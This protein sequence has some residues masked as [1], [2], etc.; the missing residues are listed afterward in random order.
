MNK[1]SHRGVTICCHPLPSHAVI[2]IFISK[3][4]QSNTLK[5]FYPQS[6]RSVGRHTQV[7]H[8]CYVVHNILLIVIP[9]NIKNLTISFTT[10]GGLYAYS[11]VSQQGQTCLVQT[12][13]SRPRRTQSKRCVCCLLQF[14]TCSQSVIEEIN[15]ITKMSNIL[16]HFKC[17]RY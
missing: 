10:Y 8:T 9:E 11:T 6:C 3:K 12:L 16:I 1:S 5:R 15:C 13:I 4:L 2:F 14:Q 17:D 7:S